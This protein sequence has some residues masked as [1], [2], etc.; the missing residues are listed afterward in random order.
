MCWVELCARVH[1]GVYEWLVRRVECN[2]KERWVRGIRKVC[3][4]VD[5]IV[6]G[7]DERKQVR[8]CNAQGQGHRAPTPSAQWNF[9]GCEDRV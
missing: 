9:P 3:T 8:P 6:S 4:M 1:H 2:L 7:I 5:E